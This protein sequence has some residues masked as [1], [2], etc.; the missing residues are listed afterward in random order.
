MKCIVFIPS[1]NKG[2]G[3]VYSLSHRKMKKY[4]LYVVR[5]HINTELGLWAESAPCVHCTRAIRYYGFKKIVYIDNNKDIK[6]VKTKDF[7]TN[8]VSSCNKLNVER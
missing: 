8:F 1:P 5:R 7:K 4:T 2:G 6:V 3:S